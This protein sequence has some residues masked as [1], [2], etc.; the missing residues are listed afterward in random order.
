MGI[1]DKKIIPRKT[2]L[3]EQLVISD[4]IPVVPRNRKSR[5]SVPNPSAEE[6]IARN[7]VPWS[8]IES[9]SHNS[10]PNPSAEENTTRNSFLW[11]QYRSKFSEFHFEPFR[12]REHNSEFLSVQLKILHSPYSEYTEIYDFIFKNQL[13]SKTFTY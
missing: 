8:K 7:S 3:T 6:K 9:N 11:N 13:R 10:V 5:N 12:G 4:G 2:E 1:S